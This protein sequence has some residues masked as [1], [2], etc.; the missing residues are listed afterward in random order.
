MGTRT[1][2]IFIGFILVAAGAMQ[3][4][5]FRDVQQGDV[6]RPAS[7]AG[8]ANAVPLA[9]AGWTG[10]D[11]PLGATEFV[12]DA[13]AKTLNYDE[14]VNR[15]YQRG[16]QQFGLYVGYWSPGRMPVQRVASH[17]PDRCWTE[18]GWTC[19]EQRFAVSLPSGSEMLMPGQWRRFLP[20]NGAAEQFVLYWHLV[21]GRP[22]DYGERFNARPDLV[23]WWRDTV[24][25]AFRG[26]DEQY[27][28]R[29]T[30]DRLFE[31][32]VGDPGFQEVLTAVGKL[33][34]A[35]R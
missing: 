9:V 25:Y 35:V 16:A 13:V 17:T 19:P 10:R 24:A 30:S 31:Q 14:Y 23:K 33:G 6:T 21:G 4:I 27:F 12:R 2:L 1:I 28:I 26:S 3:V 8:L 34:L 7:S 32:L 11:E 15:T 29:L 22:Y 18:S 20:P 5:P